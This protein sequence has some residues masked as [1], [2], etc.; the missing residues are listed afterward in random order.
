MNKELKNRWIENLRSGK[1][2][3]TTGQLSDYKKD[4]HYCCL[5][6]LYYKSQEIFNADL[7]IENSIGVISAYDTLVHMNDYE[8][9]SFDQ[10]ADWIEINL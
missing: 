3:Q 5:G 9:K 4:N 6:V 8:N 1:Y 7:D 10:I 2:H